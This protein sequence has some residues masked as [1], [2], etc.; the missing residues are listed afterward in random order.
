MIAALAWK[1]YREQRAIWILMACLSVLLFVTISTLVHDNSVFLVLLTNYC[2]IAPTYGL[3][4]GSM[5]LAGE[6][7]AGTL[8]F[9]DTLTGQ[10][11]RLWGTKLAIGAALTLGQAAVFTLLL[12]AVLSASHGPGLVNAVG[13]TLTVTGWA[14]EALVCGLFFSALFRNALSAA[15]VA[16]VTLGLIW[17]VS[18]V[19]YGLFSPSD[20]N[21]SFRL[22]HL[23]LP[24]L[25]LVGSWRI[26]CQDD[27]SRSFGF[28]LRSDRPILPRLTARTSQFPL[29]ALGAAGFLLGLLAPLSCLVLWPFLMLLIGAACGS[30]VAAG[31]SLVSPYPLP[32]VRPRSHA[33]RWALESAGWFAMAVCAVLLVL[34]GATV[35]VWLDETFNPSVSSGSD[36]DLIRLLLPKPRERLR[37]VLP[38]ILGQSPRNE[39]FFGNSLL[40]PATLLFLAYGFGIGQILLL[41]LKDAAAVIITVLLTLAVGGFFLPDLVGT[42]SGLW[43]LLAVPALLATLVRA[44][45]DDQRQRVVRIRFRCEGPLPDM[46]ALGTL[47]QGGSTGNDWQALVLNPD[48]QALERLRSAEGVSGFEETPVPIEEAFG[49]LLGRREP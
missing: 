28:P 6:R 11:T 41:V 17:F 24:I 39:I 23:A 34:V 43:L 26:F 12:P 13:L 4:C 14:L 8:A 20:A 21:D 1:E 49:A 10:R 30:R 36:F 32:G 47:L 7:E 2:L 29:L 27:L 5:L 33:Q 3:V 40:S 42:W 22:I 46:G 37:L 48:P 35:H 15:G 25:A 9:L 38:A 44:A 18:T 19:Y 16:A 31:D 45:L